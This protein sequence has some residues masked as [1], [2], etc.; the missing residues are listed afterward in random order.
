MT[1][2]PK[3]PGRNRSAAASAWAYRNLALLKLRQGDASGAFR[4]YEQAWQSAAETGSPPAGLAVEFLQKLFEAGQFE[5]GAQVYR[6]LPLDVQEAERI[7]ILRGQF[8]L[9]LDDL[10]AVEQVLEREYATVREGETVLSD[11]WTRNACPPG[12]RQERAR[13]GRRTAQI[14]PGALPAS[15][16]HRFPQ[17]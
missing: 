8:A 7:Q 14:R 16:A 15:R 5:R 3:P 10:D 17:L 6:S 12:S 9:A 11:L 2:G 4:F 13:A 1:A